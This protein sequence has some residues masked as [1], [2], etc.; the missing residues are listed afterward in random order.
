MTNKKIAKQL[1]AIGVQRNDAAAF[2]RTYNK[3][4]AAKREDLFP[5]IVE[6]V[7]QVGYQ[8]VNYLVVPIRASYTAHDA[9]AYYYRDGSVNFANML[10]GEL[11]KQIAEA[12]LKNGAIRMEQRRF[13]DF[14]EYRAT[15]NVAMPWE[16]RAIIHKHFPDGDA[17]K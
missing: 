13:L 16:G 5:G 15:V 9:F 2:A 4:K 10:E 17:N 11:S 12:L 7:M 8:L 14:V 3:I 1:M 6:P